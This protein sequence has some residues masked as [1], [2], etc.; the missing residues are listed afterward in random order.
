MSRTFTGK[1][2]A[3]REAPSTPDVLPWDAGEV[4][5]EADDPDGD[6][7]GKGEDGVEHLVGVGPVIRVEV[8][9]QG[10]IEC[11]KEEREN[12]AAEPREPSGEELQGGFGPFRTEPKLFVWKIDELGGDALKNAGDAKRHDRGYRDGAN[13]ECEK[14]RFRL[15]A[16]RDSAAV[17]VG[18]D[19][20][21]QSLVAGGKIDRREDTEH[22]ENASWQSR[23]LHGVLYSQLTSLAQ[24][25]A[26][27]LRRGL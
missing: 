17:E 4:G 15:P 8:S 19:R 24:L 22:D 6:E 25:P 7:G 11:K 26:R 20:V 1:T 27:N 2:Y 18:C 9:L 5:G 3:L 21:R 10:V 14:H 12:R 13:E 23:I 16:V